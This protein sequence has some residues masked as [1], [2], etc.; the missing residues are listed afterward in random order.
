MGV[1]FLWRWERISGRRTQDL[2]RS[3][4]QTGASPKSAVAKGSKTVARVGGNG[5]LVRTLVICA[6][7]VVS[8]AAVPLAYLGWITWRYGRVYTVTPREVMR[9]TKWHLR[10][11]IYTGDQ[12]R[13]VA[14]PDSFVPN[15]KRKYLALNGREAV[16]A[17]LT[18]GGLPCLG[19]MSGRDELFVYVRPAPDSAWRIYEFPARVSYDF[20]KLVR[21]RGPTST[22]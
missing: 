22:P 3:P 14:L 21:Y 2:T 20:W 10:E 18:L 12:I 5:S 19:H 9:T 7:L 15:R 1:Y 13:A 17:K 4:K 16:V 8:V 6:A 11:R